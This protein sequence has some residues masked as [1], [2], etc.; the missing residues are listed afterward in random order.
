MR[1]KK[2]TYIELYTLVKAGKYDEIPS[3]YNIKWFG[4]E[5]GKN[6][7]FDIPRTDI[8]ITKIGVP[9]PTNLHLVS[10]YIPDMPLGNL[11][12]KADF[13][14]VYFRT[15][16]ELTEFKATYDL[17]KVNSRELM[18][19]VRQYS[20]AV[21]G[22]SFKKSEVCFNMKAV[23][24]KPYSYIEMFNVILKEINFPGLEEDVIVEASADL[25]C[26]FFRLTI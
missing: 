16:P 1:N 2:L 19:W 7:E 3:E 23:T 15:R 22:R 8:S 11:G 13:G 21:T 24:P 25:I 20:E 12:E 26:D 10:E 6:F 17:K 18:E 9:I 4:H 5:P 14:D